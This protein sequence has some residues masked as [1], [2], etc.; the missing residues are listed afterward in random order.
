M[1]GWRLVAILEGGGGGGASTPETGKCPWFPPSGGCAGGCKADG[2]KDH[3]FPTCCP[4]N[5]AAGGLQELLSFPLI[6]GVL[7]I[8]HRLPVS[9]GTLYRSIGNTDNNA[10]NNLA[11]PFPMLVLEGHH[12][13]LWFPFLSE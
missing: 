3:S 11:N 2:H 12:P 5:P 6:T 10:D 4:T 9:L 13:I 8:V 1:G 7:S